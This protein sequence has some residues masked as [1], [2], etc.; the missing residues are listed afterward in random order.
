MSIISGS[1]IPC[2]LPN[3]SASTAFTL[4]RGVCLFLRFCAGPGV[5][6]ATKSAALA[7]VES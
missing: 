3:L 1:P 4:G 7:A 2:S 6:E 5:E